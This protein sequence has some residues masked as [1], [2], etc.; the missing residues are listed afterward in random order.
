MAGGFSMEVTGLQELATY[1]ATLAATLKPQ[2]TLQLSS[3]FEQATGR[4][5]RDVPVRTGFL[6]N[7]IKLNKG[8][9]GEILVQINITA[10]YAGF[11][12]FGTFRMRPRPFASN[13]YNFILSEMKRIS[14]M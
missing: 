12:N 7:S 3:I 1:A 10:K 5:Q 6:K 8:G 14:A 11:V 2:I 9:G 4:M 13:G